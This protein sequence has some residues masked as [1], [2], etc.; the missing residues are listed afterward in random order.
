M[1]GRGESQSQRKDPTP[2]SSDDAPAAGGAPTPTPAS[3]DKANKSP[4]SRR[5]SRARRAAEKLAQESEA[6]CHRTGT[7]GKRRTRTRKPSS[8]S[9]SPSP[10]SR[11]PEVPLPGAQATAASSSQAPPAT[12]SAGSLD[13]TRVDQSAQAAPNPPPS[14]VSTAQVAP[15]TPHQATRH[16]NSDA[17]N[18]PAP[19]PNNARARAPRPPRPATGS[20][21]ANPIQ[22]DEQQRGDEQPRH[23]HARIVDPTL[24]GSQPSRDGSASS[25]APRPR[26]QQEQ[27]VTCPK[28]HKAFKGLQGHRCSAKTITAPE[29]E[30]THLRQWPFN[31]LKDLDPREIFCSPPT[32]KDLPMSCAAS[33]SSCFVELAKHI[34][35]G[36]PG[37]W[38]AFFLLPRMVFSLPRGGHGSERRISEKIN[39]FSRGEWKTLLSFRPPNP[40]HGYVSTPLGKMKRAVSL[41]RAGN[42]SAASRI[43]TSGSI[44]DPKDAGV[45]QALQNLHPAGRSFDFVRPDNCP[46]LDIDDD[47][48]IRIVRALPPRRAADA[49]GW[50]GEYFR[51]L[52]PRAHHALAEMIIRAAQRPILLPPATSSLRFRSSP[53]GPRQERWW[54]TSHCSR[55]SF[56]QARVSMHCRKHEAPAP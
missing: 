36:T 9:A 14:S 13:S 20:S 48:I 54:H 44:Q 45:Y 35:A 27:M 33:F 8:P 2:H 24:L 52:E 1:T 19:T 38:H 18:A 51:R 42:L 55:H 23:H 17:P 7:L 15:N 29:G 26:Q 16:P 22:V 4:S 46:G 43:L 21:A 39:L 50:R 34:M 49:A 53:R 10:R 30:S 3:N 37:A 6:F 47:L 56:P 28:C 5:H 25:S 40:S 41:A 32:V 12:P 11:S 31:D